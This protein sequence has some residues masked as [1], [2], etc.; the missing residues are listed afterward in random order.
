MHVLVDGQ[1]L[2]A[3][4]RGCAPD[5]E[6]C[7]L[8]E[9]LVVSDITRRWFVAVSD[10]GTLA[11]LAPQAR[12][13]IRTLLV[14]SDY[15]AHDRASATAAYT[16]VLQ[17]L[18][19]KHE[20]SAYW[21]LQPLAPDVLLPLALD[22]VRLV[23]S[24]QAPLPPPGGLDGTAL[25]FETRELLQQR[26]QALAD[27]AS[28]II[29]SSQAVRA[30]LV[31]QA[32]HAALKAHV[33]PPG[34]DQHAFSPMVAA[35]G[36]QG[37][38]YLLLLAGG[39]T[40]AEL[41]AAIAA[42]AEFGGQG[43]TKAASLSLRVLG[44]MM[45]AGCGNGVGQAQLAA[46]A[47]QLQIADRLAI[48]NCQD[49]AAR[50]ALVAQAAAC[51]VVGSLG[52]SGTAA[53]ESL[54]CG[55]PVAV[56]DGSA[57]A[58]LAGQHAF[59]FTA[60]DTASLARAMA[61]AIE[62]SE[63][64]AVRHA[65]IAHARQFDWPT[66]A[67][68]HMRLFAKLNA[69]L[70]LTS[71]QRRLRVG[72]A[73]PWPHQ[74][75][76][77]ADYSQLL[78]EKLRTHCDLTLYV[79]EPAQCRGERFGLPLK[80][81]TALPGEFARLDTV[82]YQLGNNPD[83]HREIYRHAWQY[84]GVAVLHDY[85]IHGFLVGAFRGTSQEYLLQAAQQ[86]EGYAP[87]AQGSC[88]ADVLEHPLCGAIVAR[89]R[90]VVVHSAWVADQL[91]GIGR[92]RVIP[93]GAACLDVS[94]ENLDA[95]RRRL[96]IREGE[97]VVAMLGFVNKYKRLP[98]VLK[99]V[100]AVREAGHAVRLIVAGQVFDP[101]LM[102]ENRIAQLGLQE[103]VTLTGYLSESEFL[104]VIR[105]ADVIVNLR[106]PSVGESSGTLARALGMGKPCL[107]SRYQQFAELPDDVCWKA[108]VDELE[109]PQLAAYLEC[110]IRRPEVRRALGANAQQYV[111]LFA[112]WELAA[113]LYAAC[114]HEVCQDAMIQALPP[115]A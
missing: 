41:A 14:A 6:C 15:P 82:L 55:V 84:P 102:V 7:R 57:A 107:V 77:I 52:T 96:A 39:A 3:S 51:V 47:Q 59:C 104:D 20:V 23:A 24:I 79:E 11:A 13:R 27:A 105:L 29:C 58:E 45:Q 54:A 32:P 101:S 49:L 38:P 115:A 72:V 100:H 43:G 34:I 99:A 85:S 25:A 76:G 40:A 95:M 103:H 108:D 112:S 31:R 18:C 74:R 44:A 12:E 88:D 64:P 30:S 106:C 92:V 80:P 93:H 8:L 71:L 111:R 73:T 67:H 37:Q 36:R 86:F 69:P 68:R 70:S 91:A 28:A 62:A 26:V 21:H 109:V 17:R 113:E 87:S 89:S 42:F 78:V 9:Q 4:R 2:N 110:L 5:R 98:S 46:M 83:F 63:R 66:C 90:A 56:P 1:F 61:A 53:L 94:G 114:L 10:K 22:D 97:L 60:G 50:G 65:G 81:I 48:E 75:T 35:H 19:R 33:I 16:R